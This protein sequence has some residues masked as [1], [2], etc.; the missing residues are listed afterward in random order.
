[1]SELRQRHAPASLSQWEEPQLRIGEK[2]GWAHRS[3]LDIAGERKSLSSVRILTPIHKHYNDWAI[4]ALYE[5]YRDIWKKALESHMIVRCLG[6]HTVQKIVSQMVV[7]M[8]ALRTT[9]ALILWNII[10]LLL[11]L[12]SV[13]DQEPE[14]SA[15]GSS[16]VCVTLILS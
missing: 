9:R 14:P 6:S 3:G 13:R 10:F 12:I 7:R 4:P 11:V 8:S 16:V 5:I 1:M 15:A 2:V